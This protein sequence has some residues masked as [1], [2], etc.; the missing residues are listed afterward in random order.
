MRTVKLKKPNVVYLQYDEADSWFTR[1]FKDHHATNSTFK[2]E[3]RMDFYKRKFNRFK[4]ETRRN[5]HKYIKNGR[6]FSYRRFPG[7]HV[8]IG[9]PCFTIS[10]IPRHKTWAIARRPGPFNTQGLSN[11]ARW[12][13]RTPRYIGDIE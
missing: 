11:E 10:N 4:F 7:N 12:S 2:V 9:I 8:L 3:T 6:W 13:Y 1:E 5:Y